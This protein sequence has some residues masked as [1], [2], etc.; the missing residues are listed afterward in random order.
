MLSR[1]QEGRGRLVTMNLRKDQQERS[2]V[3]LWTLSGTGAGRNGDC[4]DDVTLAKPRDRARGGRGVTGHTSDYNRT[5]LKPGKEERA[6]GSGVV[7][8]EKTAKVTGPAWHTGCI[9]SRARDS[10]SWCPWLRVRF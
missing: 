1:Q 2:G 10:S 9:C 4:K 7:A 3:F 6:A 8:R 5:W